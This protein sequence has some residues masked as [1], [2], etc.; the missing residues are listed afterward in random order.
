MV[1]VW[2]LPMVQPWWEDTGDQTSQT[3]WNL[4]QLRL[5]E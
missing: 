5:A 1:R 4:A 2:P 3:E